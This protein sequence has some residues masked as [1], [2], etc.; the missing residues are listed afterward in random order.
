MAREIH[1]LYGKPLGMPYWESSSLADSG[2][3]GEFT[4]KRLFELLDDA[5]ADELEDA[6]NGPGHCD[7]G[8]RREA[9]EACPGP[10]TSPGRGR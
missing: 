10:P 5:V 7:T 4:K 6:K 3:A 1:R 2:N 9:V 8:T